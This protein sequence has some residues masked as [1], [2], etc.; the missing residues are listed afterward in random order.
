MPPRL[1]SRGRS[2][3]RVLDIS[4]PAVGTCNLLRDLHFRRDLH[5]QSTRKS[6]ESH[7]S[8][9]PLHGQ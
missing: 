1:S 6:L 7:N 4:H 8:D 2:E 3:R 9:W 5:V